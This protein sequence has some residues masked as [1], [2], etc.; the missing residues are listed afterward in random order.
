MITQEDLIYM[1]KYEVNSS[2]HYNCYFLTQREK[3]CLLFWFKKKDVGHS[4][5]TP[6]QKGSNEHPRTMFGAKIG[7]ISSVMI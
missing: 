3:L 7:K 1:R 6:H 2:I 4:L 5:E